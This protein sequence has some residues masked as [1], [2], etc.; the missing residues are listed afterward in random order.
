[1]LNPNQKEIPDLVWF[2]Y[3]NKTAHNF[4]KLNITVKFKIVE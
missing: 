3:I 1:M 2:T 4:L